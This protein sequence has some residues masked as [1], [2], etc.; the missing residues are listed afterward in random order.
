MFAE[1]EH[2]GRGKCEKY[3]G[4]KPDKV[5]FENA[6]C[7]AFREGEDLLPHEIVI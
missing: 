1:K 3:P 5:Y 7:P 4:G 6:P 2:I